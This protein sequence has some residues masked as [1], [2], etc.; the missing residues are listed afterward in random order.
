MIRLAFEGITFLL[1]PPI[2]LSIIAKCISSPIRARF[3][4][5]QDGEPQSSLPGGFFMRLIAL[6]MDV[7]FIS[8]IL[9][10]IFCIAIAITDVCNLAMNWIWPFTMVLLFAIPILYL[11]LPL[12]LG[13]QTWGKKLTGLA[14]ERMD[15][16]RIGLG[17]ALWRGLLVPVFYLL[18][19]YVVGVI[20]PLISVISPEKRMLHDRWS[21]TR[22][23]QV[24]PP[25]R[26]FSALP[27]T[28][29]VFSC[30][31]IFIVVRPWFVQ[32]YDIPA[33][34]MTP[35]LQVSDKLI[36]DKFV[37]LLR[38]PE[39][40]QIIVF[41]P[42]DEASIG[43]NPALIAR[44]WL[45]ENPGKMTPGEL[46]LLRDMLIQVLP[47]MKLDSS[48]LKYGGGKVN[49]DADL[50]ALLPQVTQQNFIKRVIGLPGD[51]VRIAGSQVYVNGLKMSEPYVSSSGGTMLPTFSD[52]GPC[53]M[54][55]MNNN[56]Y[57][58][59]EVTDDKDVIGWLMNW[60]GYTHLRTCVA[61]SLKDGEIT[62][63]PEAVFVMG[64]NR[65][66]SFDSRYWGLIP[67]KNIKARAVATFWP[68][69]RLKI[70]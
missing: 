17:V 33:E 30:M 41:Q 29:F 44:V 1:L 19:I 4:I 10:T 58:L 60:Y 63:P 62:I 12:T 28:T 65:P 2:A 70:L 22:V 68:L 27:I 39:R 55:K 42:P 57:N 15:G 43:N 54:L 32:T 14:V 46:N 45:Q 67:L 61:R 56:L 59:N 31:F 24:R 21:G 26:F 25:V 49:S 51:H 50:L 5:L 37:Y 53:P 20:D 23:A 47:T 38:T 6:T 18:S 69:N 7:Y 16:R 9:V 64:D 66:N 11:A 13:R 52:P 8:L 35:T 40:G 3:D 36:A 34:S 48:L